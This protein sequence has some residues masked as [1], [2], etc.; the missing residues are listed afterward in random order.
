MGKNQWV[1]PRNGKWAVRGEG[2]SEDTKLFDNKSDVLSM[3]KRF[4]K[5]AIRV[6]CPKKNGQIQS[7]DSFGNDPIPPR[8][9]EH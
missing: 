4:L 3:V 8:D 5:T 6:Y 2:N 1:S 7:K 9:K